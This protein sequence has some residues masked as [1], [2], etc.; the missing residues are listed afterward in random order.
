MSS[1][2]QTVPTPQV[3]VET[4]QAAPAAPPVVKAPA[5]PP[6]PKPATLMQIAAARAADPY[7]FS[8]HCCTQ[9]YAG[10]GPGHV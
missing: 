6:A 10:K 5:A 1:D 8:L 9:L 4:P 3:Q 7:L 2:D